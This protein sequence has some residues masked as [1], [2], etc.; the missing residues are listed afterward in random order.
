M[1]Q[2]KRS[3]SFSSDSS[4]FLL[5]PLSLEQR[6]VG[7]GGQSFKIKVIEEEKKKRKQTFNN[8]HKKV[9]SVCSRFEPSFYEDAAS[10]TAACP[11][12]SLSAFLLFL[13]EI[14]VGD[15]SQPSKYC[16]VKILIF[17]FSRFRWPSISLKNICSQRNSI[18]PSQARSQSP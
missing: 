4:P 6:R 12:R 1:S 17:Y 18:P 13:L 3:S 9:P 15:G 11:R 7:G 10:P 5:F 16:D 14:K 2:R 8:K